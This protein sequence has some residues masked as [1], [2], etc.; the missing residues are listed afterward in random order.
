MCRKTCVSDRKLNFGNLVIRSYAVKYKKSVT[1]FCKTMFSVYGTGQ[2]SVAREA[3]VVK[4]L[5]QIYLN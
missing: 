1:I 2:M 3:I 5:N 4:Y